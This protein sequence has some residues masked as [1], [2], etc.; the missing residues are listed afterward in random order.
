MRV[1][2]FVLPVVL[3]LSGAA[4]AQVTDWRQIPKPP[5]RPFQPQQ[6]VR[7]VLGNGLVVLLQRDTE[8]PLVRGHARI[9]GGSREEP[10]S[11]VGLVTLFGD[12]W[13]TG[14]TE[15]R[16]GDELD[17]FLEARAASV[18]TS[19]GLDSTSISFDCLKDNLD[20]VFA[21]FVE[22]IREPAFREDKLLLAK[23]DL[24]TGIARRNDNAAGIA[25]REARRLV[26][27]PDSPYG[28]QP[29]YA[30]LAA[31]TR[32]DLVAWHDKYVHP[33]DMI[34]GVSGDFDLKDMEARIRKAFGSWAKGPTLA[35]PKF[36]FRNPEPGFYYIAKEDVNQSNIRMVH[37]GTTRDNPDYYSIEVMNE[38]FGGGFS[39]RLFTD[40]RSK[41]GLA[42][43]VGGGI[44]TGFDAPGAFQ[45]GMGTKS[46]TTAAAIDALF[47]EIDALHKVPP[48]D[49]EMWR[50]KQSILN[51]FVFS[52]DS[53]D[54]VLA[55]KMLY[56]FYGYPSDFLERYRTGIER[57]TAQD[58]ERVAR[59][60]VHREALAVLVVGKA[61]DFDRPLSSFG[62]VKE[63]DISI[64]P[65]PQEGS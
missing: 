4:D 14:G 7:L 26:Y 9:R 45:V 42:Y 27:G 61:A 12:T 8:L 57:V 23:D 49:D 10:A 54:K 28:R 32:T 48:S 6:P 51:S 39:S 60:Y 35:R 2:A 15:S 20:E 58:V 18:E 5:L 56:E 53:P 17:D 16:S 3:A 64:P 36:E 19:G 29:E 30:T 52:F 31:V 55:E 24:A 47:E 11:K 62:P 43:G 50:A 1:A 34:L 41:K 46:E 37:L 25:T 63:I 38:I 40:I 21:A 33:N 44:G 13:R 59:K 22:L 65:P